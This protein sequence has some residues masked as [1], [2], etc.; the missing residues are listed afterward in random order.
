MKA[1]YD[2]DS[3]DDSAQRIVQAHRPARERGDAVVLVAHNGPSGLGDRRHD[4]CGVDW[5]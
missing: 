4:I 5:K 1:V 2:V 3:L